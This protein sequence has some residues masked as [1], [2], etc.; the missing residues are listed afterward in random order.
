LINGE[1][2]GE[3]AMMEGGEKGIPVE[4]EDGVEGNGGGERSDR[5]E[6]CNVITDR[7]EVAEVLLKGGEKVSGAVGREF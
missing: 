6:L 5:L 7:V 4:F 1:L 3:G 2:E